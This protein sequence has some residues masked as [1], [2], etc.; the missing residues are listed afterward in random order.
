MSW[1]RFK[2]RDFFREICPLSRK[3]NR[4]LCAFQA[5]ISGPYLHSTRLSNTNQKMGQEHGTSRITKSIFQFLCK[6]PWKRENSIAFSSTPKT[7]NAHLEPPRS[8]GHIQKTSRS[9]QCLR[10][11]RGVLFQETILSFLNNE[12]NEKLFVFKKNLGFRRGLR[13]KK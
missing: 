2:F 7:K 9:R 12:F 3:K 1:P 11:F 8:G 13:S 10:Y 4:E 6:R 5:E